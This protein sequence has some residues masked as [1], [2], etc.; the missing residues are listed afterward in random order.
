MV[1]P[2]MDQLVVEAVQLGLVVL[3]PLALGLPCGQAAGVVRVGLEGSQLGEGVDA[4][5]KGDL[6]GGQQL[7]ILLRQLVFLL[8]LRDDLG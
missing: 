4:A 3:V 7:F 5:L 8:Q 6:G 2:Q 1:V